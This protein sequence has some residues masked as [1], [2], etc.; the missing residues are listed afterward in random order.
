[1]TSKNRWSPRHRLGNNVL[2]VAHILPAAV[3]ATLT[4]GATERETL[5]SSRR[6]GTW[7]KNLIRQAPIAERGLG[8]RPANSKAAVREF[9]SLVV[10]RCRRRSPEG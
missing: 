2:Y 9:A 8:A 10:T 5:L 3:E 6:I 7:M 4:L 1:M